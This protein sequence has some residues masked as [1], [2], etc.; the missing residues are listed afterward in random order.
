MVNLKKTVTTMSRFNCSTQHACNRTQT[1]KEYARTRG[2][3]YTEF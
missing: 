1:Q 2:A 3:S